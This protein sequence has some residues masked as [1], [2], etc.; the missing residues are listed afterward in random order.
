LKVEDR[1]LNILQDEIRRLRDQEWGLFRELLRKQDSEKVTTIEELLA[2]NYRL[3]TSIQD[4]ESKC[5]R[6]QELMDNYRAAPWDLFQKWRCISKRKRVF[7]A[8]EY[9]N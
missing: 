3:K 5:I 1:D 9:K 2:E 6:Q 7:K 4:L 8:R